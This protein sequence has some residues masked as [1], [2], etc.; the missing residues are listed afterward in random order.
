MAKK[1]YPKVEGILQ[2]LIHQLVYEL[3]AELLDPTLRVL[4]QDIKN[5]ETRLKDSREHYETSSQVY[6]EKADALRG[7][8]K[9]LALEGKQTF[10]P[11]RGVTIKFTNGYC[12]V[13]YDSKELDRLLAKNPALAEMVNPARK[14]K[15]VDPRVNIVEK[16]DEP[17]LGSAEP[18]IDTA[19]AGSIDEPPF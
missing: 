18:V 9:D 2:T 15:E 13:T 3:Q 10:A 8:I 6:T 1:E 5:A 16:V 4:R 12:K 11:E 17:E 14:E 7:R 19:T